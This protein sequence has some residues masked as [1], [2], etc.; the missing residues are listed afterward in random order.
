MKGIMSLPNFDFQ[1]LTVTQ[2]K[3][4]ASIAPDCTVNAITNSAVVGKYR[5]R[6]PERIYNLPN[7]SC[8]NKFCVSHPDNKQRDVVAFFERKP[9]YETSALPKCEVAQY[10]FVCKYCL[11][12][13]E[14]ENIWS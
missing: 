7:I 3:V 11:W 1:S 10:L 2:M 4:I 12:P 6:V 14:Y 13:H 5:L 9:F 8:K